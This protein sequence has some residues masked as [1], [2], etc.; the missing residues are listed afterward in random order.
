MQFRSAWW[1]KHTVLVLCNMQKCSPEPGLQQYQ[2]EI[3]GSW[4]WIS[5]IAFNLVS[6]GLK[7]SGKVIGKYY[8]RQFLITS[9]HFGIWTNHQKLVGLSPRVTI[10]LEFQGCL[11]QNTS[12][13]PNTFRAVIEKYI[14]YNTWNFKGEVIWHSSNP[15]KITSAT[16]SLGFS[17][18]SLIA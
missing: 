7:G 4:W 13:E 8:C 14:K 9:V 15:G 6:W 12:A 5:T 2:S 16:S 18:K 11:N 10:H 1:P 17:V 3:L